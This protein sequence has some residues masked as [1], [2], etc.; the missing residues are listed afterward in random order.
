MAVIA[1]DLMKNI[2]VVGN[3][4]YARA[5][6]SRL[7]TARQKLERGENFYWQT[8]RGLFYV[9]LYAYDAMAIPRQ[10]VSEHLKRTMLTKRTRSRL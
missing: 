6:V 9:N 7:E 3:A 1:R 5:R 2:M 8:P 10:Q 4:R